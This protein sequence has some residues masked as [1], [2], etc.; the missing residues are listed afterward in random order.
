[1]G[2]GVLHAVQGYWYDGPKGIMG[3]APKLRSDDFT[4]FFTSAEGWGNIVQLRKDGKQINR[5][6]VKYGRL[7]LDKL[8]V[9]LNGLNT[10]T[11]KAS[12][13]DRNITIGVHNNGDMVEVALDGLHLK[14]GDVLEVSF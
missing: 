11:V 8:Q 3:F 2:Y 1:M 5:V 9:K 12:V 14:R 7:Y 4:G 6:E 13:N 10:N